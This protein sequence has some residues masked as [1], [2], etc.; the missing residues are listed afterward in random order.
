MGLLGLGESSGSVTNVATGEGGVG[1][2]MKR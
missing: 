1:A 2:G